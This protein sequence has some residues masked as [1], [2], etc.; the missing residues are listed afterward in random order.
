[1]KFLFVDIWSKHGQ[2]T[3]MSGHEIY[4]FNPKNYLNSAEY[5]QYLTTEFLMKLY[6]KSDPC[7][8]SML[9]E[10]LNAIYKHNI[11]GI[12]SHQSVFPPEWLVRNTPGLVRVLGC[13]DDP[14]KTY[15]VTLPSIWAYHGAYYCSP[16]YS[17]TLRFADFLA[18]V[19]VKHTHWFPLSYTLPTPEL[20]TA[21]ESSWS[22]RIARAVYIG[23]CYGDKVDKLAQIN[24]SISG[25]LM[26][27]GKDWPMEG[28]AGFVAP[29]RGRQYFPR[30]V[31]PISEKDR[32]SVYLSSLIGLNMHMGTHEETGNM[33]MYEVPMHGAMLLS[34]RAGCDAHANIF[35]PDVEAVY[36][37]CVN[38][39]IEKC[40]F[41]FSHPEQAIEIARRGFERA[42]RD[43]DPQ[44]TLRNLLDWAASLP[45]HNGQIEL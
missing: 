22:N 41:Y 39:A 30:C 33:R 7:L 11:D 23:K 40:R 37:G 8:M 2:H 21:V 9:D 31:R 29:L 36:Y 44:K 34:D 42:R 28:L 4:Y 14:H 19:G 18:M 10:S 5:K 20:I 24:R 17:N 25:Q 32:R 38:E 3:E 27:F 35:K 1:M 6:Q 26:I 13:F 43:Y 12:I 16:S 45:V 15:S